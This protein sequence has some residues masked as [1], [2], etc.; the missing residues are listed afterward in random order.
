MTWVELGEPRPHTSPTAYEPLEWASLGVEHLTP[1]DEKA[2]ACQAFFRSR[3]T[4]RKF[5]RLTLE[6]LSNFLYL[7]CATIDRQA[8]SFGFDIE[9]RPSISAGALHPIHTLLRRSIELPWERYRSSEH[10]LNEL[11][12]SVEQDRQ[13]LDHV[14][15]IVPIGA[16]VLIVLA[17]E[18]GRAAA[19]YE[20]AASLVWRDAGALLATMAWVA[21]SLALSFCPLGT[22][23]DTFV[24][25][26]DEQGRL[27]G[28]GAALLGAR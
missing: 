12:V 4:R 19:K 8:S 22:T 16:A 20:N 23:G 3:R 9:Q 10:Q 27:R 1:P 6:A 26:L 7:S 2:F 28:V 14:N 5:R 18:P 21:E 11:A 24:S 25:S 13:F 15:S 17:A